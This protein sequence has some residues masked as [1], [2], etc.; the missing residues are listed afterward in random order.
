MQN[1]TKP[2]KKT[3]L[4]LFSSL[5]HNPFSVKE[6]LIFKSNNGLI[7]ET[8]LTGSSTK[9]NSSDLNT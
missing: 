8:V 2:K 9:L 5:I 7:N 6:S 1:L 3:Y 4:I